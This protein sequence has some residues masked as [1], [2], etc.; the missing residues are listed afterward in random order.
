[1]TVRARNAT[2]QVLGLGEVLRFQASL[3]ASRA[4]L[5][6]LSWTQGFEAN[7]LGDVAAAIHVGLAGTVTA[8]ASMLIAFQ[9]GRMRCAG[10]VLLPDL[11][12]TALANVGWSVLVARRVRDV[13][14]LRR[15]GSGALRRARDRGQ[16]GE[17]KRTDKNP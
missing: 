15:G 6:G 13:R 8:L 7:D 2:R 17:Q 12:M 9:Q 5:R 10:E 11:L 16:T 4:D 14:G 3:M 1:M